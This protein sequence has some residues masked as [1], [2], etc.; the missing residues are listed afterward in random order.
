MGT[1]SRSTASLVHSA[2]ISPD[3]E[4]DACATADPS[5]RVLATTEPFANSVTP[6]LPLSSPLRS[7]APSG[8]HSS[9]V[10]SAD[11]CALGICTITLGDP[12]LRSTPGR[13]S[14]TLSTP[15]AYA[16][17]HLSPL[18]DSLMRRIAG[19]T[20]LE[21]DANADWGVLAS[22]AGSSLAESSDGCLGGETTVMNRSGP[23][24]A[25]ASGPNG[26]GPSARVL[27]KT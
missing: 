12:P 6:T 5:A 15:V 11:T 26:L 7:L 1:E 10:T 17:A 27:A 8:D 22:S 2:A 4:K 9:H 19:D 16:M 14:T 3:A 13:N 24:G 18:G 21:R 25:S 23:S 20:P